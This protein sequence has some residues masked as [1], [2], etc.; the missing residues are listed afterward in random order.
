MVL[1]LAP[2]FWAALTMA[3]MRLYWRWLLT[4]P[5]SVVSSKGSPRVSFAIP[6]FSI[7]ANS[8]MILRCTK[9]LEPATQLWPLV[10]KIAAWAPRH[11]SSST[12]SANTILADLPPSSNTTGFNAL[13]QLVA[14]MR[15]TSGEPTNTTLRTAA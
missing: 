2:A 12:A 4:G 1:I 13:P 10:E 3:L 5:I 7:L 11:A 6:A 8:S 9:S 15:P 14:T